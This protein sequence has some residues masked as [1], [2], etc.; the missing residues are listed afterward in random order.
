[1]ATIANGGLIQGNPGHVKNN[2]PG[3]VGEWRNGAF[4]IQVVRVND[5]GYDAFTTNTKFSGGGLQGVAISGLL[6][7]CTVFHHGSGGPYS[8][9]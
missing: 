6:W 7:E 1:M 2:T 5:S 9:N 4:T 8:P 3:I